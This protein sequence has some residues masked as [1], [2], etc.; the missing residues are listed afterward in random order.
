MLFD[1][2]LELV[3][4]RSAVNTLIHHL[5]IRRVYI[6]ITIAAVLLFINGNQYLSI[7]FALAASITKYLY[8]IWIEISAISF[9]TDDLKFDLRDVINDLENR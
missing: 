8:S 6:A 1:F 5:H 7:G 4:T 3:E 2:K 9:H